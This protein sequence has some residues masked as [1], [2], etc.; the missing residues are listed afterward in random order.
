MNRPV[1]LAIHGVGNAPLGAVAGAVRANIAGERLEVDVE[2][3]NWHQRVEQPLDPAT[4]RLRYKAIRT[5]ARELVTAASI[6]PQTC[7]RLGDALFSVMHV[8]GAMG[9][10]VCLLMPLLAFF[11]GLAF[12]ILGD[13]DPGWYRWYRTFLTVAFGLSLVSAASILLLGARSSIVARRWAPIWVAVRRVA[14][15]LTMPFVVVALLPLVI[16]WSEIFP[17]RVLISDWRSSAIS[18][19]IGVSLATFLAVVQGHI[20]SPVQGVVMGAAVLPLLAVY[21]TLAWLSRAVAGPTLKILL[22]IFRY[23]GDPAYRDKILEGMCEKV[24][25]HRLEVGRQF[26][27]LSHSLGSV[28]A[29]DSLVNSPTWCRE[30]DVLLITMGSPLS[31]FFFRFFP[32]ALFPDDPK[33]VAA[34]VAARVR[35]FAW[36]NVYRPLDPIGTN[37]SLTATGCGVD[38]TTGQFRRLDAHGDYFSDPVVRDCVLAACREVKPSPGGLGLATYDQITVSRPAY[39][40]A[41]DTAFAVAFTVAVIVVAVATAV[42]GAVGLASSDRRVERIAAT[43][44]EQGEAAAIDVVHW[45]VLQDVGGDHRPP[46]IDEHFRFRFQTCTGRMVDK[47]LVLT[48]GDPF[49]PIGVVSE[50]GQFF[51]A[52]K[53]MEDVHKRG[54]P[55]V[56]GN[57]LYLGSQYAPHELKGVPIHLPARRPGM[58]SAARVSALSVL[59]NDFPMAKIS[60]C[61]PDYDVHEPDGSNARIL[62]VRSV[63]G[64]RAFRR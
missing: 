3:Y 45:S 53:L 55:T 62:V 12:D 34:T 2:E 61:D 18:F 57:A 17:L 22:D 36:V 38:R 26:V 35:S 19:G 41:V 28:I 30:D 49:L 64:R 60:D 44:Q 6:G 11:I 1:L 43:L 50:R 24:A 40:K 8:T 54:R 39:L 4:A 58:V 59:A 29:V 14:L 27:L 10:A 47:E 51:D 15:L 48:N 7:G 32:N 46:L 37:L 31:R 63:L 5:I 25:E 56:T 16:P 42:G 9:I 13:V 52:G 21:W 20:T 33:R 23:V